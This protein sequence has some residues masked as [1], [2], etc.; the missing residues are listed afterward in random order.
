MK[1]PFQCN[2]NV[3]RSH[4]VPGTELGSG[5]GWREGRQTDSGVRAAAC[6]R[7]SRGPGVRLHGLHSGDLCSYCPLTWNH[8]VR[9][10][11]AVDAETR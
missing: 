3:L 9:A 1:D 2:K 5:R 6:Q 4:Q 7:L 11:G 10:G 8:S